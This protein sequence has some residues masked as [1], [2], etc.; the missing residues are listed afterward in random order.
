MIFSGLF[1][2]PDWQLEN[3]FVNP[4]H[5]QRHL[6]SRA[7]QEVVIFVVRSYRWTLSPLKNAVLGST[8]CCRFSPTCSQYAIEA[9]SRIGVVRGGTLS[10]KRICRCHPWGGCGQDPVPSARPGKGLSGDA[11]LPI[12]DVFT[13]LSSR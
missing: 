6:L 2:A 11:K 13:S 1:E 7:A 12:P 4:L 10:L 9:V 3:I 8:G 5:K